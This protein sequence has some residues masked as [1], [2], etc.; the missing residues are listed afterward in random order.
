MLSPKI[1][2]HPY[3][4]LMGKGVFETHGL[5]QLRMPG[6]ESIGLNLYVNRVTGPPDGYR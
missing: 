3:G 2:T 4:L 5:I 6:R 1:D